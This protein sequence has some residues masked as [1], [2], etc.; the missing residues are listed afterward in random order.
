MLPIRKSNLRRSHAVGAEVRVPDLGLA[1]GAL[2][3]SIRPTSLFLTTFQE[4]PVGT[5]VIVELSLPDGPVVVDGVVAQADDPAGL[6]LA[7][8]LEA[9]DDDMRGRLGAA[10][11]MIPPAPASEVKVA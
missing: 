11:S 10:S 4:L 7:I 9:V 1:F 2:A 6:G 8:Q 5:S 3:A